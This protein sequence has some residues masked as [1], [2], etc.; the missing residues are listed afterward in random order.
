EA[1]PMLQLF[2]ALR[3]LGSEASIRAAVMS[4]SQ[5]FGIGYGTMILYTN[6]VYIA[7]Q[8]LFNDIVK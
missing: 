3:H 1:N 8:S 7:L 6:Q 4:S 5:L 2:I